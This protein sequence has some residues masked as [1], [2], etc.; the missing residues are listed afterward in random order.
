MNLETFENLRE[1][2]MY[3]FFALFVVSFLISVFLISKKSKSVSENENAYGVANETGKDKNYQKASKIMLLTAISLIVLNI[4][5]AFVNAK[6]YYDQFHNEIFLESVT[7]T[8][9]GNELYWAIEGLEEEEIKERIENRFDSFTNL[10]DETIFSYLLTNPH[11]DLYFTKSEYGESPYS[12]FSDA[13]SDGIIEY[14]AYSE[15]TLFYSET[16]FFIVFG[17]MPIAISLIF[18]LYMYP[19]KIARKKEHEQTTAIAW[20]NAFLG[21]TVI[22]WIAMLMWANSKK[23]IIS[24]EINTAPQHQTIIQETDNIEKLK[25]LLDSGIITQEEFEAK[26]TELLSKI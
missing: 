25:S 4:G 3:V 20:I 14:S 15:Y 21:I 5:F 19:T 13:V 9:S 18:P 2:I 11:E 8:I 24:R 12:I 7:S 1:I 6:Q 22:G 23:E 26:R 16:P 17:I 10:E